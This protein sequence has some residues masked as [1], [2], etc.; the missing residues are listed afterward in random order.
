MH[1]LGEDHD[2]VV[3]Q[4]K[5]AIEIDGEKT[6]DQEGQQQPPESSDSEPVSAVEEMSS[7]ASIENGSSS[8]SQEE[9]SVS[10]NEGS[11]S[12]VDGQGICD[13]FF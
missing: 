7:E 13:N 1:E 11:T 4:W 10:E 9:N 12:T 8:G 6:Q 2:A 3:H 5:L